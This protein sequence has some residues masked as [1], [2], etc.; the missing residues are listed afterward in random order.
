MK[1]RFPAARVIPAGLRAD[2][3]PFAA[4]PDNYLVFASRKHPLKGWPKAQEL[5]SRA[6]MPLLTVEGQDGALLWT[7]IGSARGLL[8]LSTLDA[9]PRLP[10]EAAAL[11]VPTICYANNG[12]ADHVQHGV[13]GF[14]CHNDDEVLAAIPKLATLD[15]AAIRQWVI[16]QHP[17]E[18]MI[19][20]YE[21]ALKAAAAG[22]TW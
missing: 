6:G 9:G 16:E 4:T 2:T 8:H 7:L 1:T 12:T 17:F 19:D 11:G 14:V 18:A 13:T 22:E 15:R 3:L 20:G 5:A 10:L 21:A